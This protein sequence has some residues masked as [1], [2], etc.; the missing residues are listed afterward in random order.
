MHPPIP[1]AEKYKIHVPANEFS[2]NASEK[3]ISEG[4]VAN[5]DFHSTLGKR[6]TG[7]IYFDRSFKSTWLSKREFKTIILLTQGLSISEVAIRLKISDDTVN[8]YVKNI[9]YKLN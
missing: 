2:V 1:I 5:S 4:H 3:C 8:K 7:G 6:N 9:K